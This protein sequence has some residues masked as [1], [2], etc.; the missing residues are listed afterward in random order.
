MRNRDG[1]A[2]VTV[3]IPLDGSVPPCPICGAITVDLNGKPSRCAAH[4]FCPDCGGTEE[5]FDGP[6]FCP[7]HACRAWYDDRTH[8]RLR[9]GHE[10]PHE[11]WARHPRFHWANG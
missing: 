8:C 11:A 6:Q 3:S 4:D 5:G 7:V 9:R 2:T 10:E 1:F